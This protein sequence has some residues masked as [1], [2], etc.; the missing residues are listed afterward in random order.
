M[1]KNQEFKIIFSGDAAV[2]KTSIAKRFQDPDDKLSGVYRP[3]IG[4]SY[5]TKTVSIKGKEIVLQIWDTAGQETFKSIA[6]LYYRSADAGIFVYDVTL[7]ETF[8]NLREWVSTFQSVAGDDKK[9]FIVGNKIDLKDKIAVTEE[10][11]NKWAEENEYFNYRVS[12]LD[13]TNIL[14]LFEL[15][16]LEVTKSNKSEISNNGLEINETRSSYCPC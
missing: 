16:A 3:T 9:V 6:P 12:A 10:E 7:R 13:N 1:E 5:S 14:E 15:V 2:G 11:A 8:K 4:A